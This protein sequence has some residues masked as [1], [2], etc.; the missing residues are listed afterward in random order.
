M[1]CYITSYYDINRE[2][3]KNKFSRTFD[4]YLSTFRPFITLFD[5]NF[6]GD[7]EMI[8]FIDA[9]HFDKVQ[10]L[11]ESH[12]PS[13]ITLHVLN[14][15]VMNELP[16]WRS[17][18]RE[19]E[20]MKSEKFHRLLGE[21]HVFPEHN[22][23]EYTLINH[24]K[25]DIVCRAIN[26]SLTKKEVLVWVD[27]GFFA[28]PSNIPL[29]LL[30]LEHFDL[31][32]VNY[33]LINPIEKI[34]FDINYTL[35]NAPEVV[36]GF[37]F[38]GRREKL[39]EYQAVY[40]EV[41][42]YFQNSIEVADDDQHF[43]LQCVVRRPD[44]FAFDRKNYGWHKV[45]KNY[46][47]ERTKVITFCL[48]GNEK[49]YTVGLIENIKL[50]GLYYPD[51][52]CWCYI[53]EPTVNEHFISIIRSFQNVRIILKKDPIVRPKRF[54]LLRLEPLMSP[55]IVERFISRDCDTRIQP[56][57][58]LA[59]DEWIESDRTVHIMRDHPQH[60][61]RILGGMYGIKCDT[62]FG[63][64]W[65][66]DVEKYYQENGEDADD[67]GYL[68]KTFY[69]SEHSRIIHDEIKRYEGDE[70]RQFPIPYEQDHRF[71]G[72]YVYEDGSGDSTTENVLRDY[73]TMNLPHRLSEYSVGLEEKL[74]F[75]A[76]KI[77]NIYIIHY[78]KLTK[79]KANMIRELRR[80]FLDKFIKI[81][82]VDN[83]D[84]E[85]ITEEK[86]KESCI[87][88]ADILPRFMTLAEIANGL[89][90]VDTIE[91][92]RDSGDELS[93]VLEDDTC[94]KKDFIHHFYYVLNHLPK[95]FDS[96]CLG[97]PITLQSV[98]C[99]M[100][101]I[102]IKMDFRSEEIIFYRPSTPAPMTLSAILHT[103]HGIEK[104]IKSQ[105]FKPFSAPSDHSMWA[106]NIDQR[107]K[108]YYAQPFLT[109]EASKTE[110]FDTS[111]DRGF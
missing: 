1:A 41:L 35:L 65:I 82:W 44:L 69:A 22:Y 81:H 26:L 43:V 97:G 23:P 76:S 38:L 85:D 33:T 64:N 52:Q 11:L 55:Q 68:Q 6:C 73:L 13:A 110:L 56:R 3:W 66:E 80:N 105:Y 14:T 12:P 67:Q 50:A 101:E 94:F 95:H 70:C 42:D 91:R 87:F 86:I 27:F 71:V 106:C 59:V 78:T 40:H 57:E 49:R 99:K 31:K 17:L 24:C 25:I 16:M 47:K 62:N 77:K 107:A 7:D 2:N 58:V 34:D 100:L 84:R 46:Q 39:L 98:P 60:Y 103:K 102:A 48:W 45:L 74:R 89:A 93:I 83:F 8:V 28:K 75:I 63:I 53:H 10:T 109:F 96:M 18:E 29:Q 37:F 104:I 30:D 111:M 21:R 54:M 88:N 79:R 19:R 61:P 36:G 32:R 51:W 108:L 92:I 90:H 15:D 20:I 9:K 72:C 4:D 5:K